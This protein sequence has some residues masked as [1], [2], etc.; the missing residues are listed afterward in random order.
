[1]PQN[2]GENG[3]LLRETN[4]KF[5]SL[6]NVLRS[7]SD[8]PSRTFKIYSK[9]SK[10]VRASCDIS[11]TTLTSLWE[12]KFSIR[13]ARGETHLSLYKQYCLNHKLNPSRV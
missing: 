1:M 8:S 12:A 2:K 6:Y 5:N 7:L 11:N 4:F 3:S 9:S 10:R 13:V